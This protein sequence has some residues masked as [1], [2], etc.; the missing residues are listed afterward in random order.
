[1]PH[2]MVDYSPN[3]DE[4]ADM[5]AF[6][7]HLREAASQL[8]TFPTPG[9]RVRAVAVDHFSQADGNPAHGFV[10]VSVRLRGG[11]AQDVKEE[12]VAVL[13]AAMQDFFAADMATNSLALSLEMRDIDPA[14]SPKAGTVRDHLSSP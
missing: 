10:D 11:R 12:A 4:R 14:L 7:N 2:F 5:A 9:I 1:M 6:C 13:F 8:D 3:M